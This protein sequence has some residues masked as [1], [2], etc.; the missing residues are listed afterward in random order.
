MTLVALSAEEISREFV[1]LPFKDFGRDPREGLDCFGLLLAVWRRLGVEVPD[2]HYSYS[3]TSGNYIKLAENWHRFFRPVDERE[4]RLGDA[5]FF[6]LVAET[7]F[8]VGVFLMPGRFIHCQRHSGV[9]VS[10]LSH[11]YYR[12]SR[13]LYYRLKALDVCNA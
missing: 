2:F 5:I 1:G 12:R 4:L 8:H 11:Q 13:K 6:S 7:V 3:D 10:K 9:I